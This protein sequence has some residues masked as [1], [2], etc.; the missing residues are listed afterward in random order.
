MAK[1]IDHVSKN[2]KRY[3]SLLLEDHDYLLAHENEITL[4]VDSIICTCGDILKITTS[5]VRLFQLEK[6][7]FTNKE[8][9]KSIVD[10]LLEN[11]SRVSGITHLYILLMGLK[12][13]WH[14]D[15]DAWLYQALTFFFSHSNSLPKSMV[16]FDGAS[17]TPFTHA[18][19]T[20]TYTK[21]IMGSCGLVS[22][23]ISYMIELNHLQLW[24]VS[25]LVDS[26][27]FK[28][29]LLDQA[30]ERDIISF[31][32]NYHDR[33]LFVSV[34]YRASELRKIMEEFK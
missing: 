22:K 33:K 18:N 7:F 2:E 21:L 30:M 34:L 17:F 10:F 32:K 14:N 29:G 25:Y 8:L 13:K 31:S 19:F 1:Y 15:N 16:E 24:Q 4:Q 26:S 3:A 27:R 9:R 23:S 28:T 20:D 11:L 12:D 5:P 6:L